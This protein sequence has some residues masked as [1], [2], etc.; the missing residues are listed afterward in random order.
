MSDD[1]AD[2]RAAKA[3]VVFSGGMDSAVALYWAREKFAAVATVSFAYGAKHNAVEH[4]HALKTCAKLG[5]ENTLIE[6]PFIGQHFTSSLLA[7]GA[8][9]PRGDYNETNM[10]STVVPFRNGI[11]LAAAA[12]F[13]E[14]RNYDYLVL[15]NHGGD[16]AIYPDC[17]PEFIDGM[18]AAIYSGTTNGV[19]LLSPFC[20]RT[21][22]AIAKIGKELG[23]DF[24]LTYSCYEGGEI[25]CGE[26]ATCRER[27]KALRFIGE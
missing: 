21:K 5:V 17:R 3:L 6:L 12:G 19:R 14:T 26:C 24:S 25:P 7:G 27:E 9:V 1:S 8:P 10:A 11:M 18:A 15:G 20:R 22:S 4:R 2:Y 16:H 23:V 13:A